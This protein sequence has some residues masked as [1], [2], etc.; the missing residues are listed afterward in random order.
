MKLNRLQTYINTPHSQHINPVVVRHHQMVLSTV[1][2]AY[3][4][5][6]AGIGIAGLGQVRPDLMMKSLI[7]VVVS[8]ELV[9]SFLLLL[10]R[11]K[12]R[13]G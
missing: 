7:P 4:T 2:A 5:A 1:G 9:S 6:K 13:V 11:G 12:G 10:V 8:G 3:G